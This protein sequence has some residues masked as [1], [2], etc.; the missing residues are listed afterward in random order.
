MQGEINIDNYEA[1]L[2]DYM[3]GHLSQDDIVLLKAFAVLHP[4]LN[5]DL[6]NNELVYLETE[7]DSFLSKGALKKTADDLV[8]DELFIGY[9]ENTLSDADKKHVEVSCANNK[10]LLKE[11]D[12]YKKTILQPEAT[13]IFENKESLKKEAKVIAFTPFVFRAAA[14]LVLL[15][16]LWFLF[17][18]S[19][20]EE[21][22]ESLVSLNTSTENNHLASNQNNSTTSSNTIA[23]ATPN[24][25][26]SNN[27]S[28]GKS[29]AKTSQQVINL[30]VENPVATN[31]TDLNNSNPQKKEPLPVKSNVVNPTPNDTMSGTAL[32]SNSPARKN[33]FVVI[34]E[35]YDED[36]ISAKKERKGFW[37]TARRALSSL[38]RLGVKKVNGTETTDVSTASE[39]YVLSLGNFHIEK[40]KYNAE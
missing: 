28:V 30:S 27:K 2:L 39:T 29:N 8:S 11:L 1:F 12:L 13:I 36:E 22:G 5:I 37:V 32:A 25:N 38:N 17:N 20:K 26:L 40:N 9:I 23:S 3:E 15:A 10:S 19:G 16:S 34:E 24:K 33:S 18:I 35:A 31:T 4:E 7:S 14:A 21:K 6:D